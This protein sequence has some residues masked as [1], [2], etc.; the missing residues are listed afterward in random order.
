MK[1]KSHKSEA[2]FPSSSKQ[3]RYA[4]LLPGMIFIISFIAFIAIFWRV[5]PMIRY[6]E[7]W[8]TF[9]YDC[10]FIA[11][12][13]NGG[14]AG[15]LFS[16]FFLQFF[17]TTIHGILLMSFLF[18][19]LEMVFYLVVK[20]F[21][22]TDI[23]CVLTIFVIILL[24]LFSASSLSK[25]SI[26]G[27]LGFP[28]A[29]EKTNMQYI[30][31]C[32]MS[33][34]ED[35]DGIVQ[36]WQQ[37]NPEKNLLNQNV[38]NMAMAEKGLLHEHLFDNP[39]SDITSIY[40]DDIQSE[41]VA[42]ML[43]DIYYSM[44]HIAQSQR[45]A[46][47]ANEKF[48]NNSPRLLQRLIKTNIIYGQY[49]VARKYLHKLSKACYYKEWCEHYAT[50][51]NDKAVISDKELSVKRKCLDIE[52]KFS[53]FGGLDKDLLMVARATRNDRQSK[54]TVQYLSALYRLAQYK[55]EYESLLK[56]FNLSKQ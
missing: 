19:F 29:G 24:S 51:L 42:A 26:A 46:F 55:D 4:Y 17:H 52:N 35:W 43:S 18:L 30:K 36:F 47:E 6:V 39:C 48:D 22:R 53:G 7:G 54:V 16:T 50:L 49:N 56:E 34:D 21:F 20:R 3:N 11:E 31:Y 1:L 12:Q 33:R 40:V 15:T 37:G 2:L 23:S 5:G 32:N 25:I 44:G 8:S 14:N 10:H 38:I 45:Y 41:Y 27:I 13:L 9:Y 28:S